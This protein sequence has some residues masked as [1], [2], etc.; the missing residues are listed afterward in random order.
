MNFLIQLPPEIARKQ[1]IDAWVQC[2]LSN[3]NAFDEFNSLVAK[4]VE[5]GSSVHGISC[6]FIHDSTQKVIKNKIVLKR[7]SPFIEAALFH[8]I[9]LN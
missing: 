7:Q 1:M 2:F 5:A 4:M 8:P 3:E 6:F 9:C